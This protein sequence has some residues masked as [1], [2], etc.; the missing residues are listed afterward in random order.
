MGSI[1]LYLREC[2]LSLRVLDDTE[3]VI[4]ACCTAWN[5]LTAKPERLRSLCASPWI[6]KVSS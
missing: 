2:F 4:D 5:A 6:T 3:A 1:W